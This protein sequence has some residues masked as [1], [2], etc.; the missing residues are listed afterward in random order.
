MLNQGYWPTEFLT[1]SKILKE[2]P[3]KYAQS[4]LY[5]EQD[6]NDLTYFHIYHLKVVQRAIDELQSYLTKKMAEVRTLQTTLARLP[7]EFNH[8]QLAVLNNAVNHSNQRYTA[9][10]HA[11]SHGVSGETAR[12]DLRYLEQRG[13]P[14]RAKAGKQH[15]WMP[16][17]NLFEKLQ[18]H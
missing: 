2:S 5:T 12:K 8:R 9:I 6:T 4:Y 7:G 17:P 10:S 15:T 13:L 18:Q 3:T 1:V 14:S 11:T 16:A